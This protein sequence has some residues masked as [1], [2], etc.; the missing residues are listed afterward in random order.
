MKTISELNDPIR[1]EKKSSLPTKA[2]RISVI[3]VNGLNLLCIVLKGCLYGWYT[4][5]DAE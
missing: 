2:E 3:E 1:R 5:L 4:L